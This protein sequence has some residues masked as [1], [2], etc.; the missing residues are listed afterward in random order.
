M[1]GLDC[2]LPSW[3]FKALWDMLISSSM[4]VLSFRFLKK[5]FKFLL[6]HGNVDGDHMRN[7]CHRPLFTLGIPLKHDLDFDTEVIA[8]ICNYLIY[9]SFGCWCG[10]NVQ[11][12]QI[13]FN[14]WNIVLHPKYLCKCH[15][16]ADI[17]DALIYQNIGQEHMTLKHG[18][19]DRT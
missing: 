7:G 8:L 1:L 16:S 14:P 11:N 18:T 3:E 9:F 12:V 13:D 19:L 6:F 2:Q 17:G 15:F 5:P 4:W 10:Y